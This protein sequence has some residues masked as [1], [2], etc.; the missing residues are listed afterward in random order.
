MVSNP[1]FLA[2][3]K[4]GRWRDGRPRPSTSP[5]VQ[6]LGQMDSP[7]ACLVLE[8]R[9]Q[10]VD[11]AGGDPWIHASIEYR[12]GIATDRIPAHLDKQRLNGVR[13]IFLRRQAH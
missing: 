8:I 2:F 9:R 10:L 6:T 5:L 13:I 11:V 3:R 4:S 12:R 1:G 7:A